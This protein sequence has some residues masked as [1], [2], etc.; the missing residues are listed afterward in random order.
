[1]DGSSRFAEFHGN[2]SV[3]W[4]SASSTADNSC[5]TRVYCAAKEESQ[6]AEAEAE[7]EEA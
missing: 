3:N 2:E 4:V 5:V 6:E 1:M 7:A